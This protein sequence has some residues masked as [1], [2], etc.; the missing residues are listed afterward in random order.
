MVSDAGDQEP[1]ALV[2]HLPEIVVGNSEIVGEE[3]EDGGE[4]RSDV[5]GENGGA[6]AEDSAEVFEVDSF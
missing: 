4:I 2:D 6:H 3:V 1:R 5:G